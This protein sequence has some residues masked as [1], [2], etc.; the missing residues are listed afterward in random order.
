MPRSNR[1]KK[2]RKQA[3]DWSSTGASQWG[4]NLGWQNP[5]KYQQWLEEYNDAHWDLEQEDEEN[6]Y[7]AQYEDEGH[8]EAEHEEDPVEAE[9]QGW[10]GEPDQHQ[11]E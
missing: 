8:K 3:T 7:Y 2:E 6:Q 4:Q 10:Y 1:T 11:P 9:A 5:K